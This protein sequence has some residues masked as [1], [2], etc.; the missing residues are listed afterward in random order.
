MPPPIVLIVAVSQNGV[1]GRDGGMPWHL[2][3]DLRRFKRPTTGQPIVMGRRTWESIGGP[4]PDR[5]NLVL[6]RDAN[7]MAAGAV[8]VHS[9]QEAIEASGDTDR[10]M[11]I[12]GGEI[13]RLFMDDADAVE[14][15]RIH[16]TLDGDT[17][18]P[19]LG[20]GWTCRESIEHAADDRHAH[21]FTF[22]S[23]IRT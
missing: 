18:F 7:F 15:T 20:D 6:T 22:E 8:V 17:T 9:T 4:L 11:V 12:G 14:I 5:L 23:W 2:P 10:I 13:Y 3:E 21:A 19:S 16:A 1:I